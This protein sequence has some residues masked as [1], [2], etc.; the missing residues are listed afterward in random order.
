ME[1]AQ[2]ILAL[3]EAILLYLVLPFGALVTL[4]GLILFIADM[5]R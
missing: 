1:A 5:R 2:I 3:N 4:V